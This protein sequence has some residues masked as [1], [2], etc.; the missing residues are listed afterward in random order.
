M[1]KKFNQTEFNRN[2]NLI[3]D[4]QDTQKGQLWLGDYYA[5]LDVDA[6][7]RRGINT[8]LTVAQGLK[9]YYDPQKKIRHRQWNMQDCETYNIQRHF[10]DVISEIENGLQKGNVLVHCAAGIS[11]SATCVIAYL[12]QKNSWNY[13]TAFSFKYGQ[14]K[15]L[16]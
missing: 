2:M 13:S 9:L 10:N 14:V 16:Y 3:V 7:V 8:V 11:R 1:F 5:A 12:M 6:L 15:K 4:A